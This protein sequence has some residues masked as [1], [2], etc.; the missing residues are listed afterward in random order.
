MKI[1]KQA[2]LYE[3]ASQI[4]ID[5]RTPNEYNDYHIEG[6]LN[7]P[8]FTNDQREKIGTLY[9]QVSVYEAKN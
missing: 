4:I 9:K 8:L 7:V 1:I 6:A 2:E 3:E 5:V